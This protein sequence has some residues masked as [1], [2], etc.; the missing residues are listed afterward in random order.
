[1]SNS[2]NDLDFG[3]FLL[4]TILGGLVG[5][6]VAL[7][8]APQSGEETRMMIRDKGIEIR[9]KV[10]ESAADARG[11]KSW[12]ATPRPRPKTCSDGARSSWKSRRLGSTRP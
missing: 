12:R 2:D 6:A 1:M 4:G 8:F 9:D 5:A 11:R 7:L 10:G 3:A